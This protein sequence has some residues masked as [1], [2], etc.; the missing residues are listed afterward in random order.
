MMT[1][2]RCGPNRTPP[3]PRAAIGTRNR[4]ANRTLHVGMRG[5]PS[6]MTAA[7]TVAHAARKVSAANTSPVTSGPNGPTAP[8]VANVAGVASMAGVAGVAS[9]AGVANTAGVVDMAGAANAR[10][11]ASVRAYWAGENCRS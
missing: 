6:G 8:S 10:S 5:M 4:I 1:P 3:T 9:M 2:G 7:I 11:A